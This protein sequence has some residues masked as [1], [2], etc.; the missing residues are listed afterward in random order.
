[1]YVSLHFRTAKQ[2]DDVTFGFVVKNQTQ[3][4]IFGI[5]NIVT[6]CPQLERPISNGS[7]VEHV[8]DLPLMP[9]MYSLDLYFGSG[10]RNFDTI[11]DAISFPVEASNVFGTG[12]LPP[13]I[14]GNIF[15]PASWRFHDLGSCS[16]SN[17]HVFIS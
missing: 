4:A 12:K 11:F 5:N 2:L 13:A 6:P 3:V 14:C 1:M 17:D 9:G 7:I 15:W 16:N 8:K 10:G